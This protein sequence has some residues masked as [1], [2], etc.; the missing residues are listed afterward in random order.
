MGSS[1][2]GADC[3]DV[4]RSML[5]RG[6][7]VHA[8]VTDPPYGLSFMGKHWDHGLPDPAVWR[9]L[10]DLL[11]PGGHLAAFGGT[12]TFHRLACNIEDAGFEMR[13]TLMWLY[14][15]GFPKSH[16]VGEAIDKQGGQEIGWFAGW[17]RE[18]REAAGISRD[19][20]ARHFP[21]ASGGM[22]G[23]VW[24][25]EAG[26]RTPSARQ[27]N[28]LCRLLGHPEMSIAE[29]EREVIAQRDGST[30]TFNVGAR[31]L[32]GERRP[33]TAPAT[34]KAAEWAGWGTAL[35]PAWEPIILARKPLAGTVAANVL[36]HGT[37][38]INVDGCRVPTPDGET[39]PRVARRQGAVNHL[40][41][42]PAAETEAEGR[43]VSRQSP[44][45]FRRE[46]AGEALGRWPANVLHD[47]SDEVEAA[48]AAF[49]ER[50]S[51]AWD[52]KRNT[53][54]T[55]DVFGAF[56]QR[57]EKPKAGDSGTASRIF[58]S[59]KATA[60]D[61]AGSKHPTV[62]PVALMR[63]LARLVCPPGGVVLDPFAGSGTTGAAAAAEGMRYVL[64][65]RDADY[66][67]DIYRRLGVPS[68]E[69]MLR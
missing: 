7:R 54:K 37:G 8:V 30:R 23:C 24:N 51:G 40:S 21:S 12:R 47:G 62:K 19:D 69:E 28:E 29:V 61:R 1:I 13:D 2:Y 34:P 32:V 15:T 67:A 63:W 56:V 4:L 41:D 33:I 26:I 68:L 5:D 49:G 58:Y 22:T 17:L 39:N 20:L 45:A 53:P 48:F 42:R 38:A 43:M 11:P 57:D 59:A 14:G 50:T 66:L 64:I 60:A 25:W 9:L 27:F 55:K 16:D 65:E 18:K 31:D 35:K 46:R 44:E 6:E 10:F 36:A 52:G 3:A